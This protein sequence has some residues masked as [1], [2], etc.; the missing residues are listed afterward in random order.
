MTPPPLPK[1]VFF[2]NC[3]MSPTWGACST[4]VYWFM[5]N[6]ISHLAPSGGII[7]SYLQYQS[8]PY[9]R[10]SFCSCYQYIPNIHRTRICHGSKLAY[11]FLIIENYTVLW[12]MTF[13]WIM[14]L[15]KQML[16]K[17]LILNC[18]FQYCIMVFW[19]TNL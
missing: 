7:F 18:I 6:Y 16:K 17:H 12:N 10:F 15:A 9:P 19:E 1:T 8:R 3:L 5:H 11:P 2:T 13:Y 4:A 14:N